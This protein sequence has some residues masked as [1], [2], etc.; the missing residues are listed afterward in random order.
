LIKSIDDKKE[1]LI[2][3]TKQLRERFSALELV[4]LEPGRFV[5]KG[6]LGFR[7][8]YNGKIIEDDYDIEIQIPDDYPHSPPDVKEVGDK[9]PKNV[10]FHVNVSNGT[11]CLG[12]PLAVKTTFGRQRNLLWFVE[13]QLVPFLFGISYKLKYG[14]LPFGELSHG[15]EGLL[16]HYKEVFAINDEAIALEFLRM[17]AGGNYDEHSM[18]PC[19]RDLKIKKCHRKVL[20][21]ARNKQSPE[22]FQK[23]YW[24]ILMF[25]SR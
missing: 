18:C 16:E 24:S 9:I 20:K 13:K 14:K 22:E 6:N 23:E 7:V 21:K 1:L 8:P 17:L 4:E 2:K 5:V 15:G 12:A 11:L 19:G 25:L 10:D 3:H